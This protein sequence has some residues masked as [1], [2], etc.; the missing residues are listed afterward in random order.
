MTWWQALILGI[1]EGLTEYLPVSSTGHLIL[2]AWLLGLD[3]DPQ[4]KEAVDSFNIVIQAGAIAAVAGLYW[5]RIKQMSRGLIGRDADG[6][7]LLTNLVVAFLPA[8][9][10][11]PFL[12]DPIKAHLFTPWP[13]IGAL[14]VGAWLMLAV[15]WNQKLIERNATRGLDDVD[16]RI[17]LLI[18][19]GQCIAMW[20][21][22]SRSMMTIV[23]ALLLGM[24]ARAAA[25]FSFLL[26][27]ITLGAATCYDAY[28]GGEAILE[29]IG[30]TPLIV[31]FVAATLSAALAVKW[32]VGFLTRHGLALFGWYRLGL[33]L[34]MALLIVTGMMA[35]FG[36]D[37][38]NPTPDSSTD[39]IT[40]ATS[41]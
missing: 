18:G 38:S 19:F 3:A 9:V 41:R 22:T 17:A 23:A 39:S 32:F 7:R 40:P 33:A 8:A 29:H 24:R 21:G 35:G 5:S 1:V 28:Q 4:V 14:F 25:E 31:G 10:L 20:P 15:A 30:V 26:G 34:L 12:N 6:R 13:V 11:G 2:T 37:T 36:P 16:W 27:L